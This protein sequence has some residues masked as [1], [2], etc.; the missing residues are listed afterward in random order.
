MNG[1]ITVLVVDDD[2][3]LL[4]L[5]ST[6]LSNAFGEEIQIEVLDNPREA[7]NFLDRHAVDVLL[8]DLEMPEMN[9]VDLQKFARAR[10]AFTQVLFLTGHS[11]QQTIL[12]A[13]ECGATDY[14]LKP[15]DRELLVELVRQAV[16]R[17]TRWRRALGE[18]WRQRRR[19]TAAQGS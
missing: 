10:N 5:L 14:L 13:L 15:V 1:T 2:A 18:T 3:A 19:E 11:T 12:D 4:R 17:V 7:C 16:Q 9:G 6:V 8:T